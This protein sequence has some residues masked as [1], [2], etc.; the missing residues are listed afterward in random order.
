MADHPQKHK[1]PRRRW[2]W[3]DIAT[4]M[5][6]GLIFGLATGNIGFGLAIGA[7]IGLALSDGKRG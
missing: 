3:D 2:T 4:G 7:A 1:E 6:I 5:G